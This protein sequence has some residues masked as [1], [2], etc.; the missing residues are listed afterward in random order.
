MSEKKKLSLTAKILI[1]MCLG[2]ALGSLLNGG[3]SA[4]TWVKPYVVDGLFGVVGTIFIN[5]LKMLVVPLVL[6]SLV[7]G[8]A[9]LDDARRVGTVWVKAIGLYLLTT[10]IAITMAL[11]LALVVNPGKGIDPDKFLKQEAPQLSGVEEQVVD[12]KTELSRVKE[13]VNRLAVDTL[14]LSPVFAEETSETA[15]AGGAPRFSVDPPP[16]LRDVL[17]NLFPS[18][19]FEAMSQGNMLQ[20]I[21]FAVLFGI[22]ITLAG[23][24]GK[25]I[26]QVFR[27]LNEVVMRLVL[28]LIELAPYG[29][30][31]LVAGT[32][33]KQGFGAI[34]PLGKYFVLVIVVLVLHAVVTYPILLKLFTGLNPFTFLRKMRE[35][36]LFAFS[37]SSSN[38]TLPITLETV[39][40]DLGVDNSVASFT[41]PLGATINMDGTAIM[42]G[43]A[44]VFIAA[45]YGIELSMTDLMT[46]IVTATIASVGTAGVPSVG[47]VMLSIVLVQIGLPV[48]GIGIIWGI[49]R[50]LD[51]TRTA[52]NVTGDSMVSLIVGKWEGRLNVDRFNQK[53]VPNKVEE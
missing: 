29:V 27:D 1:G 52:V 33:A 3:Y 34:V 24:P 31:C 12:V 49:D 30:F 50:L 11:G 16:P 37:T 19:P 5:A 32:F 18:N 4:E 45:A 17:V 26:L 2:I 14:N 53:I 42:Q 13:E 48:E 10:A 43:I 21:V 22:A 7:C 9:A 6:V 23:G 38:A 41:V 39:E 51:M 47:L 15:E 8:T 40:N 46:V 35:V 20:V 28:L 25:R 44:T 36:Q